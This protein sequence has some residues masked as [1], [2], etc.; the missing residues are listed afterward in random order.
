M[1]LDSSVQIEQLKAKQATGVNLDEQQ[2]TKLAQEA[3]LRAQKSLLE[4]E[5]PCA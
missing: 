5:E 1:R 4:Q 2:L 3:D